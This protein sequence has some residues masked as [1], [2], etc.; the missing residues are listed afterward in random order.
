MTSDEAISVAKQI[1]ALGYFETSAK[2]NQ[3]VYELFSEAAKIAF[4][5]P[6]SWI[7]RQLLGDNAEKDKDSDFKIHTLRTNTDW[8]HIITQA[9]N[10]LLSGTDLRSSSL[11]DLLITSFNTP[12]LKDA[13]GHVEGI[14]QDIVIMVL[15]HLFPRLSRKLKGKLGE[16]F[17]LAQSFYQPQTKRSL[18]RQFSPKSPKVGKKSH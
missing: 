1:G 11:R 3:G 18:K 4:A 7:Q 9:N 5:V 14:Q 16:I 12:Q 8:R 13:V 6:K 10:L 15:N 2:E 17:L